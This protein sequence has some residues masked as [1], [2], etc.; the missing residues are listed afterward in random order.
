[1][2]S[3][4]IEARP[5]E[6][7]VFLEEAAGVSKYKERR[8][9]TASRL[10]DT[11]DNLLRGRHPPGAGWTAGKLASQA[12]LAEKIP[13]AAAESGELRRTCWRCCAERSRNAREHATSWNATLRKP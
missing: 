8:K 13:A 3:R 9:G 4:I 7:Q 10:N 11:R 5:E 12:E 1:M 2:I 6:L